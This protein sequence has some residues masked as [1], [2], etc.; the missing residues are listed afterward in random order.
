MNSHQ[1]G[2]NGVSLCHAQACSSVR[3]LHPLPVIMKPGAL[4]KIDVKRMELIVF[5]PHNHLGLARQIIK[6]P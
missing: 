3:S 2:L 4:E 6:I 1:E 5:C